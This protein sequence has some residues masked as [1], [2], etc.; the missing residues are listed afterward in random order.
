VFGSTVLITSAT[1]HVLID[2]GLPESAPLIARKI[3]ALGFHLRHVKLLLNS[4]AHFDHA[5]GLAELQRLSGAKVAVHPWSATVLAEGTSPPSDPQYGTGIPFPPL[6]RV[7]M[8]REG[9]VLRAGP[10]R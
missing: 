2:G 6:R 9:A 3:E 10:L 1:G 5:G 7:S 8:V 4:H